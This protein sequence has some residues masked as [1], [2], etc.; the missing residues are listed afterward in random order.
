METRV[1][2]ITADPEVLKEFE[3][4]FELNLDK[5]HRVERRTSPLILNKETDVTNKSFDETVEVVEEKPIE[6]IGIYKTNGGQPVKLCN[7][8]DVILKHKKQLSQDDLDVISGNKENSALNYELCQT[9]Q[10][11]TSNQS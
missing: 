2:L 11:K 7:G 10:K 9:C 6:L 5:I 4:I 3:K 1:Y 8:C